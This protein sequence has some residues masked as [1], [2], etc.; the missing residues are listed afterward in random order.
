MTRELSLHPVAKLFPAMPQADFDALAED[1]RLHGVRM[2]ILVHGG[3]ILDGRH[4]Y[5][6]CQQLGVPCPSTEWDGQDPWLEVQSRNLV[7]RHLAKDQIC[8]IRLLANKR[9]P[10]LVAP[11][12]K[13]RAEARQRKAQ[14][15]NQ[16]R[17][18]KALLGSQGPNRTA[19]AMGALLGVSG[20][21]VKRVER[22]ARMAPEMVSRVAAGELSV[23]RALRDA[24]MRSTA[25]NV[26]ILERASASAHVFSPEFATHRL[27]QMLSGE[28]A[29]WPVRHRASFL[30]ALGQTLDVLSH[31]H[32]GGA[33]N[34][35]RVAG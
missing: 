32:N 23:K 20:T 27:Q 35:H 3:Q 11:I 21:T 10:E 7:R 13:A 14:A 6:A 9:F 31:E 29:K 25:N 34:F 17:G 5:K 1:I 18:T 2:P 4:R 22:L 30:E 12:L 24:S 15:R 28:W 26:P 16:P 19:D 8:A 33:S